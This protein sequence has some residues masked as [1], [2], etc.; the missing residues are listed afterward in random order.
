[1]L[2]QKRFMPP[3]KGCEQ[4]PVPTGH[5][6]YDGRWRLW[7]F[8]EPAMGVHAIHGAELLRLPCQTT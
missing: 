1:M 4:K 5:V 8:G 6:G 3:P 7:E 2:N